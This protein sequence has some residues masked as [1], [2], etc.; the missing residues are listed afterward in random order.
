MP[1]PDDLTEDHFLHMRQKM[2]STKLHSIGHYLP[3]F[4]MRCCLTPCHEV[5]H[6][7]QNILKQVH[8]KY[9]AEHDAYYN[10]LSILWVTSNDPDLADIFVPGYREAIFLSLLKPAARVWNKVWKDA[11]EAKQAYEEW[12]GCFGLSTCNNIWDSDTGLIGEGEFGCVLEIEGH[13]PNGPVTFP[14]EDRLKDALQSL[15]QNRKEKREANQLFM[16]ASMMI[17]KNRLCTM[18]QCDQKIKL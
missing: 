1:S 8:T 14:T 3:R 11:M 12:T 10:Q 18:L 9:S 6:V 15:F 2:G 7:A 4:A 16:P 13:S 5:V 17:E